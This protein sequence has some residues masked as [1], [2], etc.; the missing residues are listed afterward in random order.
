MIFVKTENKEDS[1]KII[2]ELNGNRNDLVDEF[3]IIIK[4]L[5]TKLDLSDY[6]LDLIIFNL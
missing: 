5:S 2:S 3:T 6:E 4:H 1:I